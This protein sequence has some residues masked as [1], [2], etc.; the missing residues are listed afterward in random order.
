MPDRRRWARGAPRAGASDEGRELLHAAASP[1][2]RLFS[3]IQLFTRPEQFEA[4]SPCPMS[5][6]PRDQAR[7][8]RSGSIRCSDRKIRSEHL[9]GLEWIPDREGPRQDQ[10]RPRSL[11]S[12][13][14]CRKL[15]QLVKPGNRALLHTR[16][17]QHFKASKSPNFG[18]VRAGQA[19]AV[20][21]WRSVGLAMTPRRATR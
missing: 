1:A 19:A 6:G 5:R 17:P 4:L 21:G 13:N 14:V 9:E 16:I 20:L 3:L 18:D 11:T 2:S 10:A 8:G 7:A 15:L 12:F